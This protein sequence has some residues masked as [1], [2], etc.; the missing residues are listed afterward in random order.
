[1]KNKV[2]VAVVLI[3][4]GVSVLVVAQAPRTAE[5]QLK[6]AQHKEEVEGD[7]RGAIELYRQVVGLAGANRA[8]AAQALI[9]MAECHEKL[10]SAEARTLYE[11]VIREFADQGEA[12]AMARARIGGS[13]LAP[14]SGTEGATFRKVWE[15][16]NLY[17]SNVSSNG[18]VVFASF[19]FPNRLFVRDLA[20]GSER[21]IG[22]TRSRRAER[23]S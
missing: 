12:A 16:A 22:S 15:I 19:D 10:G 7:L 6:A 13:S 8:L 21:P 3:A 23:G 1:M 5:V 18:K 17:V 20:S 14:V 9:R 11:R 4:L 2:A